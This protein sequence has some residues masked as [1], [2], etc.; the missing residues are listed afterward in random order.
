MPSSQQLLDIISLQ[1]DV[2]KLGLDLS[3]VMDL[4]VQRTLSLVNADGAVIELAEGD[5][6]VYRA[7][8]GS[9][10]GCLGLRLNR[11]ASLSGYCADTGECLL[12]GDSES[13]HRV[14]REAC[15]VVGLR[16]MVLVP[17]KHNDTVVGVL[18]A[19]AGEPD[20]FCKSDLKVLGLLTDLVASAMYFASKYDRD[21]LFYRA[22]HDELTGL[23]NRSL[24]MDRFRN[25]LAQCAR[26]DSQL[27]LLMVD[28]DDLKQ[29]NDTYGHQAGD[30]MI[31]DF[32]A[33]SQQVARETDTVARL[34]GDEF[35]ALLNPLES[36]RGLAPAI[37]RL[38]MSLREPCL[39][40][41]QELPLKASIGGALYPDDGT[42]IEQLIGVADR[43]MYERKRV[44]KGG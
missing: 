17:L 41:G 44:R 16:S 8:A 6:M 20:R 31:R 30:A 18:K 14:D 37:T 34:G 42:D 12:C 10:Q 36:T 29:V 25:E 23:A 21:E 24:F 4:V 28:L 27:G 40:E 1:A 15:R 7:T 9:A 32:A 39:F 43:R 2:V 22:T 11:N 5:D 3:G 35:A 26:S 38:R 19:M 33:R 13:D